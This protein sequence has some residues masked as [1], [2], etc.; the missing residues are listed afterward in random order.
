VVVRLDV[1]IVPC[2]L[3]DDLDLADDAG[4]EFVEVFGWY[5][6]FENRLAADLLCWVAGQEVRANPKAVT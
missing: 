1:Q 5:P 2:E 6:Q 4:V 3:V